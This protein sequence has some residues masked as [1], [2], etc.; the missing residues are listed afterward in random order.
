MKTYASLQNV[1][2]ENEEIFLSIFKH[3]KGGP[4][5]DFIGLG[6]GHARI[7]NT[8][9]GLNV[10]KEWA[11]A[12]MPNYRALLQARAMEQ[13]KGKRPH[14]VLEQHVAATSGAISAYVSRLYAM[15][16]DGA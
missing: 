11:M 3:A 14:H 2:L 4:V 8:P 7:L 9:A 10:S 1:L 15:E 13:A 6:P 12:M 5:P 16:E